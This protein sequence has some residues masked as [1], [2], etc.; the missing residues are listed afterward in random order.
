MGLE[1]PPLYEQFETFLRTHIRD[2]TTLADALSQLT[3]IRR[4]RDAFMLGIRATLE[5]TRAYNEL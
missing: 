2:E 3:M 5:Y 4:E 1:E